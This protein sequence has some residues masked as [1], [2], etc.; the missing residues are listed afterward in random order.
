MGWC[1]K[2][3]QRCSGLRFKPHPGQTSLKVCD[4]R[5]ERRHALVWLLSKDR[6]NPPT[7]LVPAEGMHE[8][9]RSP[10]EVTIS[11]EEVSY[12]EQ[13]QTAPRPV[14]P[15]GRKMA[16][17]CQRTRRTCSPQ[18]QPVPLPSC[19]SGIS[20]KPQGPD[21]SPKHPICLSVVGKRFSGCFPSRVEVS[22]LQWNRKHE[23]RGFILFYFSLCFS[24][25][26]SFTENSTGQEAHEVFNKYVVDTCGLVTRLAVIPIVF[27]PLIKEDVA[28]NGRKSTSLALA[29]PGSQFW[30]WKYFKISLES[31]GAY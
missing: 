25:T 26:P 17:C 10:F 9:S 18:K 5:W 30:S 4:H 1:L 8:A 19:T 13:K 15:P 2:A 28:G 27:G 16:P 29:E 20:Y 11:V 24:Q 31:N 6:G 12:L 3:V 23:G 22:S 14:F 7:Q 21:V